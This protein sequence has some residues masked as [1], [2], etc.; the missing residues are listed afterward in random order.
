MMHLTAYPS[1]KNLVEY[2]LDIASPLAGFEIESGVST[3]K[4]P[5]PLVFEILSHIVK[6]KPSEFGHCFQGGPMLRTMMQAHLSR[7]THSMTPLIY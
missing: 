3:R 5:Y 7:V 2:S 1:S 4:G 6:S